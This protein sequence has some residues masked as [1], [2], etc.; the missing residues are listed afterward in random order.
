VTRK[1]DEVAEKEAVEY[2]QNM[3]LSAYFVS[4]E[5]PPRIVGGEPEIAIVLDPLDGTMNFVNSIPFYAV[6]A[7]LGAF[8]EDMRVE[9]LTVGVVM[10]VVSGDAFSAAKTVGA[11]HNEKRMVLN[12]DRS[13]SGPLVSFYSY[14]C[15]ELPIQVGGLQ[16]LTRYRT[17]GS[18][19]LEICY[20][21][22]GKLDA[23]IDVRGFMRIV[24]FAAGKIVLEEA[25]GLLTDIKGN[26]INRRL[27]DQ[28]GVSLI[29]AS[30]RKIHDWLLKLMWG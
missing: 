24:D 15:K 7:A 21:A 3:G 20:V 5:S 2:V 11:Y 23:M 18:A 16:K 8:K 25:G 12:P 14:G 29:A 27:T 19:S 28:S 17:L 10:D 4:E 13:L 9:D 22:S 26:K 6:S 1:I 30:N